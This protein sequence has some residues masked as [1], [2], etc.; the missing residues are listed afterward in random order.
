MI[1]SGAQSIPEVLRLA[2][3]LQVTQLS[4]RDYVVTARGFGG[5]P[6]AQNFCEQDRCAHRRAQ[7]LFTAIFRRLL[8]RARG[9]VGRCGAH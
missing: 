3:N 2:P 5:N 7:R 4:A 1:R 9:D 6:T 8:R